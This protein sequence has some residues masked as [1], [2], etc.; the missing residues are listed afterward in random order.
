MDG[1]IFGHVSKLG[2]DAAEGLARAVHGEAW[3]SFLAERALEVVIAKA[4]GIKAL[5]AV[6][7]IFRGLQAAP[8]LAPTMTERAL[9]SVGDAVRGAKGTVL[10]LL[11]RSV[12]E[13][14]ILRGEHEPRKMLTQWCLEVLDWAILSGR[15]GFLELESGGRARLNEAVILLAPVAAQAAARLEARPDAKRLGL[16]RQHALLEPDTNLLGGSR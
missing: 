16:T 3:D 12:A 7:D 8:L 14:S 11:L 13:R 1:D 4:D 9:E 6:V 5:P 2:R 10:N 15:A